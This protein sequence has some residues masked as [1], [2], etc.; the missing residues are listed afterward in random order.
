MHSD[1]A[2]VRSCRYR[3]EVEQPLCPRAGLGLALSLR[4][5]W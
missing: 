4:A 2:A 3:L 1:A 5:A